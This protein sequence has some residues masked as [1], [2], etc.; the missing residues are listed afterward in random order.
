MDPGRAIFRGSFVY[1]SIRKGLRAFRLSASG[2]ESGRVTQEVLIK[3][4]TKLSTFKGQRTFRTWLYRIA[5]NH[6]LNMKRRWA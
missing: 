3:V 1:A 5:A 4:I 6:V 2:R